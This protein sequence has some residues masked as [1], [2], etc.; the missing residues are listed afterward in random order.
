M[1]R[2]NTT[3]GFTLLELLVVLVIIAI[4]ITSAT[5]ALGDFGKARQQRM[6]LE[7][8]ASVL[9]L[10]EQTALLEPSTLGLQI[11]QQGYAFHRFLPAKK[12]WQIINQ[13]NLR[14]RAWPEHSRVTL[15]H[16]S[17]TSAKNNYIIISQAASIS[18]F[19][20]S[21]GNHT[22]TVNQNGKINH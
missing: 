1:K 15:Q 10:A 13:G 7:S 4:V 3:Q 22:I 18:P 2:I 16:L 5:L 17:A 20:L 6:A 21:L 11:T 8:F 14:P 19:R 12:Q 9:R